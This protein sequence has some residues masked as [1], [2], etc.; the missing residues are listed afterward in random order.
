MMLGA[1]G[2]GL[3]VLLV[4]CKVHLLV[5]NAQLFF[6]KREGHSI[7]SKGEPSQESLSKNC[8]DLQFRQIR[9]SESKSVPV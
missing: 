3:V 6:G 2:A 9:F 4:Y 1:G 5:T 7:K 8:H